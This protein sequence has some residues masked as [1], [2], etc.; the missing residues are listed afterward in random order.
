MEII[1]VELRN[2]LSVFG[3]FPHWERSWKLI[4]LNNN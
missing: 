3:L 2:I 1:A 4:A